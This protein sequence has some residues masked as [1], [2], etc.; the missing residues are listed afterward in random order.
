MK[1]V[2]LSQVTCKDR[3]CYQFVTESFKKDHPDLEVLEFIE[4]DTILESGKKYQ[5]EELQYC[6]DKGL[7]NIKNGSNTTNSNYAIFSTKEKLKAWEH[8]RRDASSEV[9]D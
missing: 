2:Y 9:S 6:Y 3:N 4:D 5:D 7:D 1:K 8:G